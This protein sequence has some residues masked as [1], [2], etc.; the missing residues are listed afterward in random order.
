M[1]ISQW[2]A[3]SLAGVLAIFLVRQAWSYASFLYA[4]VHF[5]LIRFI[6]NSLSIQRRYWTGATGS[7]VIL[8]LGYVIANGAC[9]AIDVRSTRDLMLRSGMMAS[10]N[11]IPLFLGGRTSFLANSAG[12]SLHTYYLAHHWVGRVAIMQGILHASLAISSAKPGDPTTVSGIV[13]SL[14]KL[15]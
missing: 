7:H 10:A 13:V 11:M 5:Y 14:V 12:I 15:S 2:Y 3:I 8:L 1:N 4:F 6:V 9:M